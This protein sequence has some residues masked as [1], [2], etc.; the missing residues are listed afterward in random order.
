MEPP[1]SEE[2]RELNRKLMEA[3]RS[4]G[5][6]FLV[7][8]PEDQP[9]VFLYGGEPEPYRLRSGRVNPGALKD[10]TYLESVLTFLRD[11]YDLF[12]EAGLRTRCPLGKRPETDREVVEVY[13][14][15]RTMRFR[16]RKR[17]VCRVKGCRFHDAD[18]L[19]IYDVTSL[20]ERKNL[21]R[22]RRLVGKYFD[23]RLGNFRSSR[24]VPGLRRAAS[25]SPEDSETRPRR[26]AF[27][28]TELVRL[29]S[30]PMKGKASGRRFVKTALAVIRDAPS[31]PYDG[32]TSD[33]GEAILLSSAFAWEDWLRKLGAASRLFLW[34]HWRQAEAARDKKAFKTTVRALA[35]A[36]N[37]NKR[38]VQS[39][40][41]ELVRYGLLKVDEKDGTWS[42]QYDVEV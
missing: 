33:T 2:Q 22:A 32:Y 23:V 38:T 18:G 21:L 11:C 20:M 25:E 1:E 16:C 14:A 37:V 27:P 9:N 4:Y 34:I 17:R 5:E 19:D 3:L 39:H 41:K 36:L 30:I 31:E 28:K 6:Q 29:F 35:E 12:T 8:E 7:F 24:S 26:R 13:F 15:G 42:A 10:R 40:K